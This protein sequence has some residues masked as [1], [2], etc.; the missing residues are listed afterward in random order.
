ML[1]LSGAPKTAGGYAIN[2]AEDGF[3][4]IDDVVAF[5]LCVLTQ[6]FFFGRSNSTME[7]K[8]N[9]KCKGSQ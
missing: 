6:R 7:V 2:P 4:V 1:N 5:G 3:Y 9:A 8:L